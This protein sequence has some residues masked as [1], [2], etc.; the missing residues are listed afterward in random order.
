MFSFRT[1]P[2]QR[3]R[4]FRIIDWLV[5]FFLNCESISIS[6]VLIIIITPSPSPPLS[7]VFIIYGRGPSVAWTPAFHLLRFGISVCHCCTPV[8]QLCHP[9]F[10]SGHIKAP[11]P[12][13]VGLTYTLLL[14]PHLRASSLL[15]SRLAFVRR[16][17]QARVDAHS[18]RFQGS[19][20]APPL[21]SVAAFDHEC[22][23]F[24]SQ[25]FPNLVI[26]KHPSIFSAPR[27]PN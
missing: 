4:R 16:A 24:W 7:S 14:L 5:P 10:L 27:P 1:H 3:R 13:F 19:I 25:F 18:S 26:R 17:Y 6:T 23:S 8:C 11:R 12:R 15:V 22:R 20:H 2:R 21:A 9:T